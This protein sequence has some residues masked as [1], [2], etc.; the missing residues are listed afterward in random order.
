MDTQT[1]LELLRHEHRRAVVAILSETSP[2]SRPELTVRLAAR[3]VDGETTSRLP[4]ED[5]RRRLRL[6]L[7]HN[8]LPKLSEAGVVEYDDRQVTA[9]RKLESLASLFHDRDRDPPA[10]ASS[11]GEQLAGF[12]A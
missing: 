12:Y 8:H 7:H 6:G 9:T 10:T 11:L 5:T 1:A 4:D 3:V 2:L